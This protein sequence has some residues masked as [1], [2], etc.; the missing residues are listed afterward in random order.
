MGNVG[1]QSTRGEIPTMWS[2]HSL[3]ENQ[4]RTRGTALLGDYSGDQGALPS[5]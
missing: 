1:V 3:R 4:G 2:S 5:E